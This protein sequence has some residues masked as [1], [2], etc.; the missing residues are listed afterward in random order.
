MIDRYTKAVLT[1][2]A[3]CLVI[4]AARGLPASAQ[5]PTHVVVYQF[6][7][8]AFQ[9]AFQFVQAPLPVTMKER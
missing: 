2:I 7:Q 4:I 5:V 6:G 1:V 8:T 9:Y 3:A